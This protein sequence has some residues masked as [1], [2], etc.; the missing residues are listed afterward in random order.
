MYSNHSRN[1]DRLKTLGDFCGAFVFLS[2]WVKNRSS[3]TRLTV[4][5]LN[6][7]TAD[8]DRTRDNPFSQ[9]VALSAELQRYTERKIFNST[10]KILWITGACGLL[11]D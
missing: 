7:C 1:E 9:K 8:G 4:G 5:L 2:Y 3:P 11:F 6:V 10:D